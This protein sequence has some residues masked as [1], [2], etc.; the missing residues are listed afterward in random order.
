MSAQCSSKFE[1]NADKKN[2]ADRKASGMIFMISLKQNMFFYTNSHYF[3]N[4]TSSN[5]IESIN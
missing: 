3:E 2:F 5:P 1:Q 4:N